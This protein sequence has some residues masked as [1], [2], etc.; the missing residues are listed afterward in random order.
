MPKTT[1]V[2]SISTFSVSSK[3]K[4]S[5]AEMAFTVYGKNSDQPFGKGDQVGVDDPP[6]C[7]DYGQSGE[8][9]RSLGCV[10]GLGNCHC[11][12]AHAA[13]LFGSGISVS[14]AASTASIRT[15][16]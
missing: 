16:K 3:N 14:A 9:E 8:S 1:N 10:W 5:V 6:P 11:L 4:A 2:S 15:R 7:Q 12:D 13:F